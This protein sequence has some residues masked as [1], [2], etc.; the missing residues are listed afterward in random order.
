MA[1]STDLRGSTP[2]GIGQHRGQRAYAGRARRVGRAAASVLSAR[3]WR[4]ICASSQR[5]SR[6]RSAARLCADS[7]SSARAVRSAGSSSERPGASRARTCPA[8]ATASP[9]P[10]STISANVVVGRLDQRLRAAVELVA[11]AALGGREQQALVGEAGGR[12]DPELEAGEMADRL[13]ADADLAVG[14]DGH[15]Q[16]RRRRARRCRGPARRCGGRRSAGSGVRAA[17]RDSRPSTS[18]VRSAHLAGSFSQS[19]RCAI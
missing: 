14:G 11:E 3:R 15:R 6:A 4:S 19:E 12:I 1:P 7:R 10:S 16:A 2:A 17:R 18:R 5:S 9:P 13:G 8:Q